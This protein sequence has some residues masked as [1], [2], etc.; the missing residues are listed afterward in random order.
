MDNPGAGLSQG[1]GINTLLF[2]K[3]HTS[4]A[5]HGL[6]RQPHPS[7]HKAHLCPFPS[8]LG[9][10]SQDPVQQKRSSGSGLSGDLGSPAS[11]RDEGGSALGIL[12]REQTSRPSLGGGWRWG[13]SDVLFIKLMFVTF[14]ESKIVSKRFP[15]TSALASLLSHC[16]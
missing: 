14:L 6:W 7:R 1:I 2:R 5:D 3:Q 15:L 10:P 8:V 9:L 16:H 13:K 4:R 12:G 11:C